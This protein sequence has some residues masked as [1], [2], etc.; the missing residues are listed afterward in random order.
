MMQMK[1]DH[2]IK[3][4]VIHGYETLSSN[5]KED[6]PIADHPGFKRMIQQLNENPGELRIWLQSG[7]MMTNKTGVLWNYIEVR[8]PKLMTHSQLVETVTQ[9]SKNTQEAKNL[10]DSY[11]A[12]QAAFTVQGHELAKERKQG[13]EFFR[14]LCDKMD[15]CNQLK[16][17]LNSLSKHPL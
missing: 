17:Q 4:S 13:N 15:E 10:K 5:K 14:N 9:L 12:L 8:D 3:G 7:D 1:G 6:S 16:I 2:G 11:E